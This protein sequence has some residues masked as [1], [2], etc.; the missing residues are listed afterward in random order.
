MPYASEFGRRGDSTTPPAG[1]R[2]PG[3]PSGSEPPSS[4]PIG[5]ASLQFL[6]STAGVLSFFATAYIGAMPR[7]LSVWQVLL[8]CLF[9]GIAIIA[10]VAYY[11]ARRRARAEADNLARPSVTALPAGVILLR[12]ALMLGLVLSGGV[13]A[14][15]SW[16][17]WVAGCAVVF[18]AA[19]LT[20][21]TAKRGNL[22]AAGVPYYFALACGGGGL[23]LCFGYF[24]GLIFR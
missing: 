5:R 8:D 4:F 2:E 10:A 11:R 21:T 23:A 12:R 16:F 9:A 19:W 24:A 13:A 14:F 15:I 1:P 6:I 17:Q 7:P 22:S 3:S 18:N 20:W